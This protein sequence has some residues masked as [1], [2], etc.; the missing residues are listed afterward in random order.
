MQIQGLTCR[1]SSWSD[2]GS[3]S[4][5]R[6]AGTTSL[7]IMGKKEIMGK[8]TKPQSLFGTDAVSFEL[9]GQTFTIQAQHMAISTGA[10]MEHRKVTASLPGAAE[11]LSEA[12]DFI[13]LA[14]E[15]EGLS[16]EEASAKIGPEQLKAIR[17]LSLKQANVEAQNAPALFES[18]LQLL[19]PAI[20]S[21]DIAELA[22]PA[23][24]EERIELLRKYGPLGEA[25]VAAMWGWYRGNPTSTPDAPAGSETAATQTPNT[26]D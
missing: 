14:S 23:T 7:R 11:Y 20:H 8:A 16:E 6:G 15:I 26:A 1:V 18:R 3:T 19:A 9:F 2:S 4:P 21:W 24:A 22:L 17:D 25:V 12:A 10:M 5:M 13:E